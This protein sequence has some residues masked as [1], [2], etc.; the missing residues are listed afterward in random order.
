MTSSGPPRRGGRPI[1]TPAPDELVKVN[2]LI[3]PG[4]K[5]WLNSGAAA[6]AR[7]LSKE[8]EAQL[9]VA[10]NL[11]ERLGG[12]RLMA[13]FENLAAAVGSRYVDDAWLDDRQPYLEVV[14]AWHEALIALAPPPRITVEEMVAAGRERVARLMATTDP[15]Y[16]EYLRA[17]LTTMSRVA[18][19]PAAAREEFRQAATAEFPHVA[20][21]PLPSPPIPPDWVAISL[22]HLNSAWLQARATLV[23]KNQREPEPL[24]VPRATHRET[25]G[26]N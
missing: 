11:Q 10:R 6:S 22:T 16:A 20:E 14:Y 17:I 1:K 5:T 21:R 25:A 7:V 2:T 3:T 23:A 18:A 19:F 24:A 12:R 26:G 8:I 4:M 13:V 15:R 9:Q